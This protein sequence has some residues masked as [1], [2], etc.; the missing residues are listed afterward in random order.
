M[1]LAM[2]FKVRQNN[3]R[4]FTA[5]VHVEDPEEEDPGEGEGIEE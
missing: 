3:P 2:Q 5:V 1:T 4:V